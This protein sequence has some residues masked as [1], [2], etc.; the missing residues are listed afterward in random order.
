MQVHRRT[1]RTRRGHD[2][3]LNGVW[4]AGP[5]GNQLKSGAKM[6]P[7]WTGFGPKTPD[8]ELFWS[9]FGQKGGLEAK[10]PDF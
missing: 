6:D 1:A 2:T 8:F 4:G 10:K 5:P 7:F 3:Y 9:I